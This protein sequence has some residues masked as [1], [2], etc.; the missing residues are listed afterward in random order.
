MGGLRDEALNATHSSVHHVHG[1]LTDDLRS[2]LLTE[3]LDADA[4]SGDFISQETF[5]VLRRSC[6]QQ[7]DSKYIE[8]PPR[9]VPDH[10]RLNYMNIYNDCSFH[11]LHA[12]VNLF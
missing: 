12:S 1:H 10:Y 6:K 2:E 9:L 4:L 5:Q 7:K 3:L 8:E 11:R